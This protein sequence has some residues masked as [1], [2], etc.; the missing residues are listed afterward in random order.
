MKDAKDNIQ[1]NAE[2]IGS[3]AKKAAKNIN[4]DIK[5]KAQDVKIEAKQAAGDIK[6]NL[7]VA[8]EPTFIE[9]TKE[10]ALDAIDK[11]TEVTKEAYDYVAGND[12]PQTR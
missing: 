12:H 4:A 7:N 8:Q 3:E 2:K 9:K 11:V 10:F 1:A 5:N 6:A